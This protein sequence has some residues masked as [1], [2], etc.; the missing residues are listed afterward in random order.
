MSYY[1]MKVYGLICDACG[2]ETEHVPKK[3]NARKLAESRAA[4]AA[5]EGW[6]HADGEDFCELCSAE[7]GGRP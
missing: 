5:L 3:D 4:V 1:V 2:T 6:T 7:D